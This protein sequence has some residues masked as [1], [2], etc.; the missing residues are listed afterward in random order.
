MVGSLSGKVRPDAP[1]IKRL[2]DTINT[3]FHRS[4]A[5]GRGAKA[6]KAIWTQPLPPV[7]STLWLGV[8][9]VL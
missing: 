8:I 1:I 2:M 6:K 7:G 5:E 4:D 9:S 3:N